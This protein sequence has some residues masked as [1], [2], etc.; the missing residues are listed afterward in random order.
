MEDNKY[1]DIVISQHSEPDISCLEDQDFKSLE[2]QQSDRFGQD[3][4]HRKVLIIWTMSLISIWLLCVLAIVVWCKHLSDVVL[5][6]LLATTTVNV[7]GLAKIILGNLFPR[8]N[9]GSRKKR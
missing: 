5:T 6:T 9:N 8:F 1:K 4:K 3:T 7:L 2:Q